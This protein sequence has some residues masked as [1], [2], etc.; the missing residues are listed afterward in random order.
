[1]LK[2]SYFAR[3]QGPLDGAVYYSIATRVSFSMLVGVS[4]NYKTLNNAVI[5]NTFIKDS[6]VL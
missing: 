5:K 2:K 6:A 4:E 3:T 1:M